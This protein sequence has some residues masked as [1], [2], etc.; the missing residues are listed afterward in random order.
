MKDRGR[1]SNRKPKTS[2]GDASGAK[3]GGKDK[4]KKKKMPRNKPNN[5]KRRRAS[6]KVGRATQ[7]Q[8]KTQSN[9]QKRFPFRNYSSARNEQK[10]V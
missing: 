6:A 10:I 3:H 4:N 2:Y 9:L 7:T 1:S 8:K 5:N